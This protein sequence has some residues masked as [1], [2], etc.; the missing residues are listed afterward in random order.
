[1][2]TPS[3]ILAWKVPWTEGY[4][5]WGHKE[6]DTTEQMNT[7][8]AH[9]LLYVSGRDKQEIRGKYILMHLTQAL[10]VFHLFIVGCAGSLLLHGL[11]LVVVSRAYSL[12]AAHALRLWTGSYVHGILQARIL[13]CVAMPSSPQG[14]FLTQGWNPH[15]LSLLCWQACSLPL[16]PPGKPK[17]II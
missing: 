5:P 14:I 2:A 6:L 12:V 11:S 8:T 7:H 3:S 16:A 9:M 1:M 10:N 15:L 13:E 4:S 17:P